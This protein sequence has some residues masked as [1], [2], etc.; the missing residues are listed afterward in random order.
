MTQTF[1]SPLVDSGK[2][3]PTKANRAGY[4]RMLYDSCGGS[5]MNILNALK[6]EQNKLVRKLERIQGAIAALG[7]AED[8][9]SGTAAHQRGTEEALGSKEAGK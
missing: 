1:V 6:K 3:I 8:E 5:R 4:V 9:R 7:E 2:A